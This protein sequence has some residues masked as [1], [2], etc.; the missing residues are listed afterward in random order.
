M[1]TL[2]VS[3]LHLDPDR[4]RVAAA[5]LSLLSGEARRAE[6]LYILGDLFEAWV[7]DDGASPLGDEVALALRALS[8]AGIA[9]HFIRGNRDFLLGRDFA[10]RCGMRVLPDPSVIDLYGTPTLLLHGDL[11]CTDDLPYQQWRRQ[12]R[13]PDWQAAL[14][15][16]PLA[17][18]RAMAAKA[19]TTSRAHLDGL[20]ETIMDVAPATV[21]QWFRL[22]G[23]NRMIHGHT[24]RPAIHATIVD[25]RPCTRIVLG[26]WHDDR[27]WLL[28]AE[29]DGLSLAESRFA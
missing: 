3:D 28:S 12:S 15:A 21:E 6:A 5:F 18:R 10:E 22:Y 8:D 19:R 16:Q 4:P 27:T 9:I 17:V 29:P 23:V 25:G 1:R 20:S 2:F 7:G 11:L 13:D 26:D 14:L 24:H